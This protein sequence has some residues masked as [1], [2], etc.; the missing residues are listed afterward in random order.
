MF[1]ASIS[2]TGNRHFPENLGKFHA[3]APLFPVE[4]EDE[5]D[6]GPDDVDFGRDDENPGQKL[7]EK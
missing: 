7:S 1:L 4:R 5:V 3:L 6:Q 2:V